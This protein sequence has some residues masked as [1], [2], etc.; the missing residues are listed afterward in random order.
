M[1]TDPDLD[2]VPTAPHTMIAHDAEV[3]EFPDGV[4]ALVARG[5][6]NRGSRR[7][8]TTTLFIEDATD[9][10]ALERAVA[11]LRTLVDARGDQP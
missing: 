10:A 9:V 1:H 6:D 2:L 5:I 11:R 8:A 7:R 4:L 3:R